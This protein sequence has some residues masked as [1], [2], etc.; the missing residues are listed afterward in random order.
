M[1][2]N[3]LSI[4]FIGVIILTA[5]GKKE[6]PPMQAPAPQPVQE[7]PQVKEEPKTTVDTVKK[8]M[9]TPKPVM[10][11]KSSGMS[12]ADLPQSM[13]SGK[14]T[15]QV[16]SWSTKEEAETLADFYSGKGFEPRVELAT[17]KSSRWYR[18]RL[19]W[20]GSRDDAQTVA[21]Y[22]ADRYKSDIWVVKP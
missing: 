6:E 1:I 17:V 19:G 20:Y 21:D 10:K 4:A 9:E 5:C 12:L 2:R 18:V 11:K 14:Y 7:Q 15:V 8:E 22:V 3:L 16:A 13:D